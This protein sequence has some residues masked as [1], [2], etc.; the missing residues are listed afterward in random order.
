MAET[1]CSVPVLKAASLFSCLTGLRISDILGLRWENIQKSADGGW[2]VRFRSEKTDV[3]STLPISDEAFE[4][5]GEPGEGLVFKGLTRQM[6]QHKLQTWL[7]AA[8]IEGK[9]IT[10]HCFRHTFATLQVASG[11][12]IY[13]VQH[14]LSHANVST[15]QIYADIVDSSKRKAAERL[16]INDVMED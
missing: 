13:T 4:L 14:M 5:C 12:D 3:E 7:K 10:F 2:C 11:T 8:G 6:T 1:P 15:T 16:R 9:R